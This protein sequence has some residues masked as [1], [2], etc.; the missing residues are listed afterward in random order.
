MKHDWLA[1]CADFSMTRRCVL[2]RADRCVSSA[3]PPND[4]ELAKHPFLRSAWWCLPCAAA[5]RRAAWVRDTDGVG[6]LCCICGQ[7]GNALV[8]DGPCGGFFVTCDSCATNVCG[9]SRAEVGAARAVLEERFHCAFCAPDG[10]RPLTT[11]AYT[12]LRGY[13]AF[14]RDVRLL[15]KQIR[16]HA[17]RAAS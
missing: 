6:S 4:P 5:Y 8:C 1:H 11:C 17:R 10:R 7:A 9:Y 15:A 16:R 14:P 13:K 12:W 3:L 2:A